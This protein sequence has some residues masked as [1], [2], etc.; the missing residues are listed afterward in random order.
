MLQGAGECKS[1]VYSIGQL[2]YACYN[3]GECLGGDVQ[4]NTLAYQSALEKISRVPATGLTN[5][6]QA[7]QELTKIMLNAHAGVRP[8]AEDFGRAPCFDSIQLQCLKYLAHIY[9]KTDPNKATFMKGLPKVLKDFPKRVTLKKVLPP[10]LEEL[11]NPVMVPFVLV[12]VMVIA[13]ECSISEFENLMFEPL[14]PVFAMSDPVQIMSILLHKFEMLLTKSPQKKH[15]EHVYPVLM[16]ALMCPVVQ[17]QQQA[18]H[19][20]PSF[21]QAV[22]FQVMKAQILPLIQQTCMN[23]QQVSV[24]IESLVCL[25]RLL[26]SF[27]KWI[28]QE[29]IIPFLLKLPS[30]EPGVLMAFFG[31][32]KMALED[33]KYGLTCQILATDLL[34]F[35]CPMIISSSLNAIQTSTVLSIVRKMIDQ[36]AGDRLA[37]LKESETMKNA[38]S[39]AVNVATGKDTVGD[40]TMSSVLSS[41]SKSVF[42]VGAAAQAAAEADA[43]AKEKAD[44]DAIEK[45]NAAFASFGG[46]ADVKTDGGDDFMS[47]LFNSKAPKSKGD[48]AGIA[49][50][51]SGSSTVSNMTARGRSPKNFK[52]IQRRGL[53]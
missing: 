52:G 10:L 11:K 3:R 40:G 16:R 41:E 45:A 2:V 17:M 34:P 42:D 28:M 51:S 49:F 35:C 7:L 43:K 22:D 21:Q 27:D 18:L 50:M 15:Q 31:I 8:T 13:E 38:A 20:L 19:L 4:G 23:T 33:K 1:D 9:E 30:R 25:G 26:P 24:R 37:E 39:G 12:P 32:L 46:A 48:E 14:I 6:P 53:Y 29:S 36:V 5:V 44:V 47:A